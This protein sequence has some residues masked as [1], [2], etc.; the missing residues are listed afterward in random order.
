[1]AEWCSLRRPSG[2]EVWALVAQLPAFE[3][4]AARLA[5]AYGLPLN[6]V[7]AALAFYRRHKELIDAQI[8]LNAA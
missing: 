7:K 8:A 3:G 5:S 2:V 6:A 4:D 1:M